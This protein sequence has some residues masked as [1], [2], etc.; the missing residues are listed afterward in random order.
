L[1]K[2]KKSRFK[3]R[4]ILIAL[5]I[6][7]L[8][9]IIIASLPVDK[10]YISYTREVS[11]SRKNEIGEVVKKVGLED[12]KELKKSIATLSWV[13][14]VNLHRNILRK[15]NIEVVP[16]LPVAQ[17]EGSGGKVVDRQ[18]FIFVSDKSD[19]LPLVNITAKVQEEGI[20]RAIE[21]FDIIPL[22]EIDEMEIRTGGVVTRYEDLKVIWGSDEFEKKYEILKRILKQSKSEFKGRLDFRFK[23]MV[24]LRR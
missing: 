19:S 8:Y 14:S 2:K 6:Y 18:G 11:E 1:A 3:I 24:I 16:R 21:L 7:F 15:L 20:S 9:K 12:L 4:Y 22:S 17:I 10:A 23:N 5:L 13:E